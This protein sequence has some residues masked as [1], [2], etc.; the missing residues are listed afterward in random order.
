[1]NQLPRAN[2]LSVCELIHPPYS[3]RDS[4]LLGTNFS[5]EFKTLKLTHYQKINPKPTSLNVIP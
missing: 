3:F 4:I 2:G 5:E 1:M